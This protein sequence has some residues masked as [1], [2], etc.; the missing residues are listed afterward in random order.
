MHFPSLGRLFVRYAAVGLGESVGTRNSE[1]LQ[2]RAPHAPLADLQTRGKAKA[3]GWGAGAQAT[4]HP[5]HAKLAQRGARAER[6]GER[7]A[8]RPLAQGPLAGACELAGGPEGR[9][10]AGL[11]RY[12]KSR[13]PPAGSDRGTRFPFRIKRVFPFFPAW[14]TEGFLNWTWRSSIRSVAKLAKEFSGKLPASPKEAPGPGSRPPPGAAQ[15]TKRA[16]PPPPDGEG[17]FFLLRTAG[18]GC[19]RSGSLAPGICLAEPEEGIRRL[20]FTAVHA[21]VFPTHPPHPAGSLM[22]SLSLS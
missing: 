9:G 5:G 22:V 17:A 8:S 1:N 16:L 20:A 6:T 11:T 10:G 7:E 14:P 2:L 21:D 4:P 15:A 13:W 12:P 19:S 18:A 3:L